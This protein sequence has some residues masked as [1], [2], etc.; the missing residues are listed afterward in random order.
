MPAQPPHLIQALSRSAKISILKTLPDMKKFLDSAVLPTPGAARA[1]F[2]E[3]CG[4]I[5]WAQNAVANKLD[6]DSWPTTFDASL[7]SILLS[8]Y[9]DAVR[10]SPPGASHFPCTVLR[11][12]QPP[13]LALGTTKR[14]SKGYLQWPSPPTSSPPQAN[15]HNSPC[16]N[17]GLS[18]EPCAVTPPP[19]LRRS[20]SPLD[21][22]DARLASPPPRGC[23]LTRSRRD[24]RARVL[25][26]HQ[27]PQGLPRGHTGT[28][29]QVD[30]T[31]RPPLTTSLS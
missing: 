25:R 18:G 5:A 15:E 11:A 10:S 30:N 23:S 28:L 12:S 6:P 16:H 19:P 26:A 2:I 1:V 31:R 3:R 22:S 13:P 4:S 14:R 29:L 27:P 17:F 8:L 21:D 7:L 24:G 9:H 20:T